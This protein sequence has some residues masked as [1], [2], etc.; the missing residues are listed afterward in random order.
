MEVGGFSKA[1]AVEALKWKAGWLAVCRGF[2]AV[3][4]TPDF[5]NVSGGVTMLVA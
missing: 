1:A 4:K 2:G 5:D 3:L